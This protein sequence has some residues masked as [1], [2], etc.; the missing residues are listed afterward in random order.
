VRRLAKASSA[1][2]T[3][4][5]GTSRRCFGIS[6]AFFL[7]LL[8]FTGS[9]AP[10]AGAAECPNEALRQ[11]QGDAGL[12]G[13][14]ALEMVTPPQKG[15]LSAGK[16]NF[17]P[18]IS[19][20]G[21]RVSFE[22]AAALGDTNS[23]GSPTGDLYVASRGPGGWLTFAT[24]PPA[25]YGYGWGG[26]SNPGRPI[27]FTPDFGQW[28]SL[29]STI[30]Q[31][32][33][34][35]MTAFEATLDGIW[36]PRSGLL[37]PLDGHHGIQ[38]IREIKSDLPAA[39]PD[40]SRLFIRAADAFANDSTG[41]A[42]T[43]GYSTAY[44]P[45]DPQ[46]T[47]WTARALERGL[48]TFNTYVLARGPLGEPTIALLARDSSGK[49]WGGN[50]GAFV[51]GGGGAGQRGGRNQ[52]AVSG[53]GTS[54]Y[55]SARPSQP[56]ADSSNANQPLCEGSGS[57][58]AVFKGNPLI[59]SV[60]VAKGLGTTSTTT[61][62]NVVTGVSTT[63]TAAFAIGQTVTIGGSTVAAGTKITAIEMETETLRRI[64]LSNPVTAG[65]GS[66]KELKAGA[67]P[68]AVG[69]EV[70]A[71][72]AC[73]SGPCF[74]PGTTIT[75]V[76][77]QSL[78]V[79]PPPLETGAGKT[80]IASPPL[81]IMQRTEA[82]NGDATIEPIVPE[83]PAGGGDFYEG[84][85]VDQSKVYFTSPRK[86]AASDVDPSSGECSST[87]KLPTETSK[88]CDLYLYE[89]LPGGG[90]E[91]V[92]VSAGEAAPA[93]DFTA[94]TAA[95]SPSLTAV[96][97]ATGTGTLSAATGTGNLSAATG[98]AT[99]FNAG[100]NFVAGVTTST[101]AYAIG[102]TITTT[103]SRLPANTKITAVGAGT[104]TLSANANS[105]G[106]AAVKTTSPTIN[107]LVTST[108]A[109][110]VGQAISGTN[111]PTETTIT[112]VGAGTLTLSANVTAPGT[113][114]A[115][116]AGSKTVTAAIAST[117]AFAVGQA[118]SGTGI[119]GGTTITAINGS[120]LTLSNLATA[121]GPQSLAA[122]GAPLAVGQ[123]VSGPG[124][125]SGA[126]IAAT[127]GQT[128]TLSANATATAS[129][130]SLNASHATGAG[131]N[132]YQGITA[133]SGDGSHVYYVARGVLTDAPNPEGAV[134][135]PGRLNL[136]LYQRDDANPSGR[137]AFVA[138]IDSSCTPVGEGAISPDCT[139]LIGSEMSYWTNAS[140]VPLTGEDGGGEEIGG[141]GHVLFLE[142]TAALT[143]NDKD[144]KRLDV[145]RYDSEAETLECV[146]CLPG[147]VDDAGAFGVEK[148]DSI[149][150]NPGPEFAEH[151][152]WTAEDGA[153]AV[154]ATAQALLPADI[155][156]GLSNY[157]WRD[158][159]LTLLPGS[160]E[161]P[162]ISHDGDQ[163]AFETSA[164][165]LPQDTDGAVDVYVARTDGGF[166]Q[167]AL[168]GAP[169]EGESCQG[170]PSPAQGAPSV[171]SANF[172]GKGNQK[173]VRKHAKKHK[174]KRHQK[175]QKR[176]AKQQR[177][178]ADRGVS[179]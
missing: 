76:N 173:P 120:T 88:G 116:T 168:E 117:G 179:K 94:D 174:K 18:S 10:A 132:V 106:P 143:A 177:A 176:H 104:L 136:Y 77:G 144:G 65:E 41:A 155:D 141:G 59:P 96:T 98:L 45:G 97:T 47:N 35:R 166:A 75:A 72:T 164:R 3:N 36:T 74:A 138:E 9:G 109:F 24:A 137:T 50:C 103:P 172:A 100:S 122:G 55:F 2:S 131:A 145:F 99:T 101:G 171:A 4:G 84:A 82:P 56:Q 37:T 7:A 61:E 22:S 73:G 85:S 15:N 43:N 78:T 25:S 60:I 162:A 130:A 69:E 71:T 20:D 133:I 53:D 152:R 40:L 17:S 149:L 140:A 142:S 121:N 107:G 90:S 135:R 52:G 11:A 129:G 62:P 57:A 87:V 150:L 44:L 68:F 86:L 16:A 108:G 124:I 160:G 34:A 39:S 151:E 29:Q 91:V 148:R 13:C 54:V 125:P 6:A 12:P 119:P 28:V 123:E 111:V 64:T 49:E 128:L 8:A 66:E 157:L 32:Q 92:Q 27:S 113:A 48:A 95:G 127:N 163:V 170:Q 139:S 14:M 58:G 118:I 26:V 23:L 30:S 147:G 21:D 134:A 81:R 153:T 175:Q 93:L 63:T 79:S 67:A 115:L 33:N 19:A 70:E 126:L 51:G 80:I 112:A 31:A 159:E 83:A 161:R 146:S 167:P 165:L 5:L 1:G 156:G 89:K 105:G 114:V 158:G 110:A 46:P 169:C 42:A 102:Q 178:G 38:S 154:F